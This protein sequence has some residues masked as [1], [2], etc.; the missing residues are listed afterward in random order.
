MSTGYRL[1]GSGDSVRLKVEIKYGRTVCDAHVPDPVTP[2]H[3]IVEKEATVWVGRLGHIAIRDV[4]DGHRPLTSHTIVMMQFWSDQIEITK[5]RY[6]GP[7]VI[8][9][10]GE[11]GERFASRTL[12]GRYTYRD[13]PTRRYPDPSLLRG[14]DALSPSFAIRIPDLACRV[15]VDASLC[16]E[17]PTLTVDDAATLPDKVASELKNFGRTP[18]TEYTSPL[19]GLLGGLRSSS[20]H[21]LIAEIFINH[22]TP[23]LP[24][25]DRVPLYRDLSNRQVIDR[26]GDAPWG[27]RSITQSRGT[28]NSK[29]PCGLTTKSTL[30][31]LMLASEEHGVPFG[32]IRNIGDHV[33]ASL[34]GAGLLPREE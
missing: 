7:V 15:D 34:E 14:I 19:S 4:L 3:L 31:D 33:F 27:H 8:E 12:D 2:L 28:A 11:N 25:E 5:G 29:R 9:S 22:Y 26:F 1:P 6:T 32:L 30:D 23:R 17:P 20:V 24:I 21:F 18:Q 10:R 13:A 16:D